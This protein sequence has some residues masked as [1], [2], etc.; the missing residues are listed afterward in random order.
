MGGE[1]QKNPLRPTVAPEEE[2]KPGQDILGITVPLPGMGAIAPGSGVRGLPNRAKQVRKTW[3]QVAGQRGTVSR[4]AFDFS[5]NPKLKSP[6]PDM[7]RPE[8]DPKA[9][10]L[11][12]TLRVQ[13]VALPGMGRAK[14]WSLDAKLEVTGVTGE[15]AEFWEA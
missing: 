13:G 9:V 2:R 1:E 15:V 12:Q 7:E 5:P 8:P 14:G 4:S 6:N 10:E 3:V 11:L